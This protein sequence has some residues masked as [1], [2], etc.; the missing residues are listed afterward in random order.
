M[1]IH[2]FSNLLSTLA[3]S[4]CRHLL[5]PTD[6]QNL[7]GMAKRLT[8]RIERQTETI[9]DITRQTGLKLGD[10]TQSTEE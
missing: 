7:E 3:N 1:D 9:K 4:P 8:R 6:K 2:E 10:T 5:S